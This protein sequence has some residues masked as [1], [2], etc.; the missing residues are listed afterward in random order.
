MK[1]IFHYAFWKQLSSMGNYKNKFLGCVVKHVRTQ[2]KIYITTTKNELFLPANCSLCELDFDNIFM[3]IIADMIN[4]NENAEPTLL[5]AE[6]DYPYF[7][8]IK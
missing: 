4:Q 6:L 7:D 2:Y 8:I 3:S 5:L 1:L